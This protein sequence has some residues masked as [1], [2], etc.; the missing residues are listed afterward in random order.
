MLAIRPTPQSSTAVPRG[1]DGPAA[2]PQTAAP[3]AGSSRGWT[4][5]GGEGE[6]AWYGCTPPGTLLLSQL[7]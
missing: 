2:R 6:V 3:S 4:P 5:G 7:A 1:D